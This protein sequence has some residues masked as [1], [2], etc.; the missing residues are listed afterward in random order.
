MVSSVVNESTANPV[1][2]TTMLT[3]N[4]ASRSVYFGD[5]IKVSGKLTEVRT[6]QGIVGVN[7]KFVDNEPVGQK[8][9]ASATT[10]KYGL[11]TASWRAALDDPDRD[12]AVHLVAKFD[13]S[14][15][16][17][18]SISKEKTITVRLL[19]LEIKFEY[20]KS[21]Y[22]EGES[23][24]IIFTVISLRKLVE[25]DI[26]RVNFDGRPVSVT[27][28]GI[29]NYVYETPPLSKTQHQFFVSVSKYGYSTATQIIT[30]HIG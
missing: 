3:L 15:N 17:T 30:I 18:A 24:E 20:L 16:Y 26:V 23:A 8:I 9:L 1:S 7:I 11:F 12:S 28:Y 14:A 29:G 27:S 21:F 5:E 6:G 22:N 25:P 10:R 4:T 19:P 13:G 2:K